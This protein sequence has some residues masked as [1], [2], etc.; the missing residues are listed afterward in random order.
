MTPQVA[1]RQANLDRQ[2][3]ASRAD[4]NRQAQV[5]ASIAAGAR[6]LFPI[7]AAQQAVGPPRCVHEVFGQF[8]RGG[9][10]CGATPAAAIDD[11]DA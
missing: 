2:A 10:A 3:A 7:R 11:D 4:R 1:A 9:C 5:T 6:A 8:N